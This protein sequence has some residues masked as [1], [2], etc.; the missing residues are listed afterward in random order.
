[1]GDTRIT[2]RLSQA[3]IAA[4]LRLAQE[5]CR[6]PRDQARYVLWSELNRRGLLPSPPNQPH[7][8]SEPKEERHA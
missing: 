8:E 1:M 2:L 3:E 5:E 4:L 7:R 6:H